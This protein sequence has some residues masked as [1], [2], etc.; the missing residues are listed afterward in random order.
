M[1]PL[2]L[3]LLAAVVIGVG[4]VHIGERVGAQPPPNERQGVTPREAHLMDQGTWETVG[5]SG[6]VRTTCDHGHR[7]YRGGYGLVVLRDDCKA[8]P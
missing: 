1:K 2:V 5:G 3:A 7:V 8:R 4:I 6:H